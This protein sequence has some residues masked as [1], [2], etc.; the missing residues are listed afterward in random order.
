MSDEIDF[1]SMMKT[2]DAYHPPVQDVAP[3]GNYVFRITE[4]DNT[5]SSGG[6]PMLKLR[7]E[8]DEGVQWD[9]IVISPNEFAIQKLLGLIEAAGLDRPD[10]AKKEIDAKTG[11][12]SDAYAQKL[13]GKE[14]GGLVRDQT[15]RVK[16]E[17]TGAY[18]DDPTGRQ[19]PRIKGY[20]TPA[21]LNGHTGPMASSAP[22]SQAD[23]A[24][25]A[26]E[27]IPF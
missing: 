26:A 3:K 4:L 18:Y 20:Q 1:G 2:A 8:C 15:A 21:K 22:P 13:L 27:D 11:E 19:V 10:P 24:S 23:A 12:L 7:L 16:D 25:K 9:S 6:F 14:V 17:N 5:T